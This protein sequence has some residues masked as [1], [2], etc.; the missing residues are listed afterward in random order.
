M[1]PS[2]TAELTSSRVVLQ[3]TSTVQR[4]FET[5]R[6]HVASSRTI[7]IDFRDPSSY[8]HRSTTLGPKPPE[9]RSRE[10]RD[11]V[12]S[13]AKKQRVRPPCRPELIVRFSEDDEREIED[14][15]EAIQF[16]EDEENL[17]V[18]S[19]EEVSYYTDAELI[20]DEACDGGDD[21]LLKSRSS[22]Q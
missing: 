5:V 6:A 9:K 22:L 10:S 17:Q 13:D 21:S 8:L 18:P 15:L 16:S 12:L 19:A 1:V 11:Q 2:H 4:K 3:A 20:E 14:E 7:R